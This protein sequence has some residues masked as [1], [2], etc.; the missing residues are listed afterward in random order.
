MDNIL[1]ITPHLPDRPPLDVDLPLQIVKRLGQIGA[2]SRH[3]VGLGALVLSRMQQAGAYACT[4]TR[5]DLA[6]GFVTIDGEPFAAIRNPEIAEL[7]AAL[8][9]LQAECGIWS[10]VKQ[11]RVGKGTV[12]YNHFTE[13]YR[14]EGDYDPLYRVIKHDTE[15]HFVWLPEHG[16]ELVNEAR[17]RIEHATKMARWADIRT[18]KL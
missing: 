14:G 9:A 16:D 11:D 4:L 13:K 15:M 5:Q 3:A 6:Q 7:A 10:H 2:I 18:V 17:A 1:D 8:H 12:R